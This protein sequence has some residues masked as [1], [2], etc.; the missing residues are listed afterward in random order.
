MLKVRGTE[1]GECDPVSN[2]GVAVESIEEDCAS[3]LYALCRA[4]CD[5]VSLLKNCFLARSWRRPPGYEDPSVLASE[6][7]CMFFH[8]ALSRFFWSSMIPRSFPET[9]SITRQDL[10]SSMQQKFS[11]YRSYLKTGI[12]T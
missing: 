10:K 7:V 4:L 1:G 6:T 5:S 12:L 8:S 9:R 11:H 2:A 3:L